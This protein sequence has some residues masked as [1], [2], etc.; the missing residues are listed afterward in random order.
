MKALT[1]WIV[2]D[3]A[4]GLVRQCAGLAARLGLEPVTRRIVIRQPWLSLPPSLWFRPLDALSSRGDR[5]VAPWPELVIASGRKSVAPAAAI[6]RA[7][8]DRTIVVQIQKPNI[9][10]KNFDL[11]VAPRH[12]GLK[13]E[14][15]VSTT[16]SLHGLTRRLL[17]EA[18]AGRAADAAHLPRPLILAA[19][20]GPNR[21]YRFTPAEA[22]ALGHRLGG[23]E[24]GVLVT[25]SRR[26]PPDAADALMSELDPSRAV[27]WRGRGANPYGGWLGLADAIVTTSDSVN[28]ATEAC[29]T[30]KPVHI[31]HLPGGSKKFGSFHESL[32]RGGHARDF[33]GTIDHS[34]RPVIL[35]DT[36]DVAARVARL[37]EERFSWPGSMSG[38]S[39]RP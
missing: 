27:F 14:N 25:V 9:G 30:G 37:L 29:V 7:A 5:L 6:R 17:D 39:G 35:D 23:L 11:V 34:W 3:G 19:I 28:M 20:G 16:G 36:G 2:T 15:V 26:T 13:G 31:A 12:D 1:S 10:L 18:A 8:G 21:V 24:G 33:D 4:A 38:C 22:R 32:K